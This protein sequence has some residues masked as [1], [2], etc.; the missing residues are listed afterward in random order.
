MY[1]VEGIRRLGNIY[2][3]YI[4]YLLLWAGRIFQWGWPDNKSQPEFSISYCRLLSRMLVLR[5]MNTAF[6]A[7]PTY[8][9]LQSPVMKW[10]EWCW[11]RFILSTFV[12]GVGH[13]G[14]NVSKSLRTSLWITTTNNPSLY[15]SIRRTSRSHG[16]TARTTRVLLLTQRYCTCPSTMCMLNKA[17]R[18]GLVERIMHA[19]PPRVKFTA[20]AALVDLNLHLSWP[21]RHWDNRARAACCSSRCGCDYRNT[22]SVTPMGVRVQLYFL[23]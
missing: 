20:C 1:E 6:V 2:V 12:D 5:L 10:A 16:L 22:S 23:V 3:V 8:V 17:R 14:V 4:F 18:R 15:D 21:G 13:R 9:E 7:D 11:R 19:A